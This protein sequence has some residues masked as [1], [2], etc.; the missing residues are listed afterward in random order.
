MLYNILSHSC[1]L[2]AIHGGGAEEAS[3]PA[4]CAVMRL[5]CVHVWRIKAIVR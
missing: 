5:A 4:R 2:P 1:T 3:R